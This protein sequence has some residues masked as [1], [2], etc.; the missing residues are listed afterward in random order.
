VSARATTSPRASTSPGARKGDT[1]LRAALGEAAA[2]AAGAKNTH[3]QA[4]YRRLAARRGKKR[5]LVAVS[6]SMLIAIWHML[7]SGMDYRDLGPLH[8]LTRV[9]PARQTQRLVSQL[10]QLGYQV[11]L[12]PVGTG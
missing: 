8:F 7:S 11:R 4:R 5:A 6:H 10:Q 12:D 2:A 3:L 9:N 1:W